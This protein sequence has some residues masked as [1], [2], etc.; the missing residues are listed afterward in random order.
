LRSETDKAIALTLDDDKPITAP[1]DHPVLT[2][3]VMTRFN[4]VADGYRETLRTVKRD[5]HAGPQDELTKEP[6]NPFTYTKYAFDK[7]GNLAVGHPKGRRLR[8]HIS[9]VTLALSALTNKLVTAGVEALKTKAAAED[10][11][12]EPKEYMEVLSRA[13]KTAKRQFRN[14]RQ[15]RK[16]KRRDMQKNSRRI[17]RRRR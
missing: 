17:N 12:P 5:D 11:A 10:R 4:E 15:E 2:E 13:V 7:N 14:D 9:A 3:E 6:V 1:T 16:K 8:P